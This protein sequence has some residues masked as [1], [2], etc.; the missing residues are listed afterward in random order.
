MRRLEIIHMRSAGESL[1]SLI[2]RISES[3]RAEGQQT[4][5]VTIYRRDGLETDLAVHI[6]HLEVPGAE[7]PSR[8]GLQLASSL[9]VFGLV[10]HTVWEEMK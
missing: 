10:E 3:I 8:L 1:E 7:G 9:R 5:V 2:D 6:H 4:N